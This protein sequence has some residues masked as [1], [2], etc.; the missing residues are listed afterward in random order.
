MNRFRRKKEAKDALEGSSSTS[1]ESESLPFPAAIKAFR[2]GRKTSGPEPKIQI[3]LASALPPSDNFRTSLLMSG[4][5]ARFSMLREQDDPNSKIGKA[6][7]DSVMFPK[8]N[9]RFGLLD[10]GSD[11]LSDIAEVSSLNGQCIRPH[12]FERPTPRGCNYSY[13]QA[14]APSNIMNRSRSGEQNNLFGGRQKINVGN[15]TLYEADVRLTAY[16]AECRRQR[17]LYH[18]EK[19]HQENYYLNSKTKN[20][21]PDENLTQDESPLVSHESST[22]QILSIDN[23]E[24]GKDDQSPNSRTLSSSPN[25]QLNKIRR[26]YEAGLDNVRQEQQSLATSKVDTVTLNRT[27]FPSV[28]TPMSSPNDSPVLNDRHSQKVIDQASLPKRS[29][30]AI[31]ASHLDVKK[32]EIIS[33]PLSPPVTSNQEEHEISVILNSLTNTKLKIP[34]YHRADEVKHARPVFQSDKDNESSSLS[35]FSIPPRS[36]DRARTDSYVTRAPKNGHANSSAQVDPRTQQ[37]YKSM[38]DYHTQPLSSTRN[39][40]AAPP[41]NESTLN[42]DISSTSLTTQPLHNAD[43]KLSNY[44]GNKSRSSS[45]LSENPTLFKSASQGHL[46]EAHLEN[47]TSFSSSEA[48]NTTELSSMTEESKSTPP[49]EIIGMVRKH[50]RLESD[51]SSDYGGSPPD[52]NVKYNPKISDTNSQNEYSVKSNPWEDKNDEKI[53]TLAQRD[54]MTPK[55]S[56][57]DTLPSHPVKYKY[58]S[59]GKLCNINNNYF[60]RK[61]LEMRH[62]RHES[63]DS[64][65]EQQNLQNELATRRR[66]VQEKMRNFVES[67]SHQTNSLPND[68][69][70]DALKNSTFGLLKTKNSRTQ[71]KVKENQVKNIKMLSLANPSSN[72]NSPSTRNIYVEEENCKN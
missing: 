16:R 22:S 19:Q 54:G 42:R 48:S 68:Y 56:N 55:S 1:T 24:S 23:E 14:K 11:D 43:T 40:L 51:A 30:S 60:I 12:E 9:S 71:V 59:H 21:N 67:D 36:L 20:S 33:P 3:D 2:L 35:N 15:R 10:H 47:R 70:R 46:Y 66:Y 38:F 26:L 27:I 61:E 63:T 57:E 72:H 31:G 7:D 65:R 44:L 41:I 69:P 64:Q 37:K 62:S 39:I 29:S 6:S 52:E 13:E 50:M 58:D 49:S 34:V 5:S 8:R 18:Q 28:P 17:N 32:P 53:S 4:L 45:T 25:F